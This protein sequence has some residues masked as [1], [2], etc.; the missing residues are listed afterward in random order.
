VLLEVNLSQ[1]ADF[2]SSFARKKWLR[3]HSCGLKK[4]KLFSGVRVQTESGVAAWQ[5]SMD[6]YQSADKRRRSTAV[7]FRSI[8]ASIVELS[9]QSKLHVELLASVTTVLFLGQLQS[10]LSKQKMPSYS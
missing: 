5:S 7:S 3:R 1:R 9:A 6:P 2:A 10:H 4:A 8:G